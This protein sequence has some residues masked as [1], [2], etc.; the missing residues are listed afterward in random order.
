MVYQKKNNKKRTAIRSSAIFVTNLEQLLEGGKSKINITI[1]TTIAQYQTKQLA[2][3]FFYLENDDCHV[4]SDEEEHTRKGSL[5][6]R[7]K[8][9]NKNKPTFFDK[10]HGDDNNDDDIDVNESA[11]DVDDA[12][13]LGNLSRKDCRITKEPRYIFLHREKQGATSFQQ[14]STKL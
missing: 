13:H 8:Y 2:Y 7:S 4:N 3:I 11:G 5:K 10:D 14:K 9:K 6:E 1:N 12:E